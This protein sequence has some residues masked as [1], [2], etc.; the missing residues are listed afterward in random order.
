MALSQY[1]CKRAIKRDS[2]IVNYLYLVACVC[3]CGCYT[4]RNTYAQ[5]ICPASKENAESLFRRLAR[6][7]T[8]KGFTAFIIRGKQ[9]IPLTTAVQFRRRAL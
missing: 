2:Y 9:H 5:D 6:Y 4:H 1:R 3:A 8:K 7:R